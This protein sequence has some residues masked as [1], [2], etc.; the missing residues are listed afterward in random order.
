MCLLVTLFKHRALL[1]HS[2]SLVSGRRLSFAFLTR[3]WNNAVPLFCRPARPRSPLRP[4][5]YTALDP[6]TRTRARVRVR[7]LEVDP[8]DSPGRVASSHHSARI[9]RSGLMARGLVIPCP[10]YSVASQATSVV[11]HV[12]VAVYSPLADIPISHG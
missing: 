8:I 3:G 6:F 9:R 2:L 1:A 4:G 5:T 11:V 10:A 7:R 12:T